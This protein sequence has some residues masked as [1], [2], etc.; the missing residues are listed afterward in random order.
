MVEDRGSRVDGVAAWRKLCAHID[1]I[2]IGSTVAALCEQG[3]LTELDAA[4]IPLDV[5]RLAER[6]GARRGYLHLAF[7]LLATQGLVVR[8]GDLG[9]GDVRVSLTPEGRAWI[10][11]ADAYR[12]VPM[13]IEEALTLS[14][15]IGAGRLSDGR[16]RGFL[17]SRSQT[18]SAV[19]H[20]VRR[21]VSGCL[22]AAAAAALL[23]GGAF[24]AFKNNLA[25]SVSSE[26]FSASEAPFLEAFDILA[27]EGWAYRDGDR[28]TLTPEGRFL[29]TIA[30]QYRRPVAY[31]PLYARVPHLLFGHAYSDVA[32]ID[33]DDVDQ[34]DRI[35]TS[36]E[37][38]RRTCRDPLFELVLPLFDTDDPAAEPRYIVDVG[39]GD[40]TML[41]ELFIAIREQTRR[42]RILDSFP[43]IAIAAEFESL[44]QRTSGDALAEAGIPHLTVFGDIGD[45]AGL[46][47]S[48]S[49]QGIDMREALHISKSVIHNRAYVAPRNGERPDFKC[50]GLA[51]RPD[52]ELIDGEHLAGTLVDLFES[53]RPWIGNHG[54]IAID[55][56]MVEP[57]A[58]AMRRGRTVLTEL[59]ASHGYSNQ[60]LVDIE[61]HRRAAMSAGLRRRASRDFGAEIAGQ[62]FLSIDHYV[63][64]ARAILDASQ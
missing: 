48:L 44:A 3:V 5:D 31:L 14:S 56:H 26:Q 58:L 25:A 17:T 7:A 21:H 42:G 54:M 27:G 22:A 24:N 15:S 46:A 39:S 8:H 49:G 12:R 9:R 23:R 11:F 55:A 57:D 50:T 1:G 63:L 18:A 52:G 29:P 37:V 6:Y 62:P 41:K 38:F 33:G 34:K 40:G 45:P 36:G 59:M 30:P 19:D 28:V 53:W 47:A 10:A 64:D 35:A 32:G 16:W 2:G 13:L 61:T 43:L 60:H 4:V 20:L 51:V